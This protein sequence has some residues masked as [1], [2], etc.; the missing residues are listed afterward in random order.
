MSQ[1]TGEDRTR[2]DKDRAD[3][4]KPVQRRCVISRSVASY[5]L[6]LFPF[7]SANAS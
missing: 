6:F 2:N 4:S 1:Q 3:S 5:H 7:Q